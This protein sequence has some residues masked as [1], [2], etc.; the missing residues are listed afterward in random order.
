MRYCPARGL[1][2]TNAVGTCNPAG[3]F[4]DLCEIAICASRAASVR[5]LQ[6]A[7][8]PEMSG[9]FELRIPA[10]DEFPTPRCQAHHCSA[11]VQEHRRDNC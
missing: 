6:A 3:A 1:V 11:W 8:L 2:T 4:F 10:E 5:L 7:E 9:K